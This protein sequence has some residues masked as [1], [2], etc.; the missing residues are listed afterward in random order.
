MPLGHPGVDGSTAPGSDASDVGT[1]ASTT[2]GLP[3]AAQD[4][5]AAAAQDAADAAPIGPPAVR[6]IGRF[7]LSKPDAP[8]A[9]WSGS[10]MEARFSG[11]QVAARLGGSNNY[12]DVVLDGVVQPVIKT[13]GQASNA[14]AT[15]LAAGTH[16][17][18]VFRRDE[19]FDNPATFSGFDFGSG[20][21]LAPPPAPARRI[22]IVGDSISAGYGDECANAS[23]GFSAATENEYVAYGP[24]AARALGADVHV[25]AWSG[26]GLYRNL[27]GSTTETMPILWKRTIPTDASSHWDSSQ[28]IPDVVVINLGTNDYNAGGG[29]PSASFQSTYLQFVEQLE[30]C[31]RACSSSARSGR[32][33]EARATLPSRRPSRTS[34]RCGATR[35]TRACGSSSSP[36]R[37]AA[38]MGPGADAIHPNAAEH[39]KMA[40]VLEAAVRSALGWRLPR[41]RARGLARPG[42]RGAGETAALPEVRGLRAPPPH[43]PRFPGTR[44]HGPGDGA[45]APARG[46]FR[47]GVEPHARQGRTVDR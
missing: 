16:D 22:E 39:Q 26:K 14:I 38:P 8:S 2:P 23:T 1:D 9:E 34:C 30:A 5:A 13:S 29:D 37:T 33:S 17:V 11:T 36:R 47:H 15:G 4:A 46:P 44:A 25:I 35:V 42:A 12:F 32:C 18:L 3:D 41:A 7:D 40:T 20:A 45:E 19:A 24:L 27:D 21:L 31:I 28:W 43:E 6:Y 10:A